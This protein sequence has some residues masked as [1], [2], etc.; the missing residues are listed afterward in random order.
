MS[1]EMPE[2]IDHH[3]A[4]RQLE[5]EMRDRDTSV[6]HDAGHLALQEASMTL[7]EKHGLNGDV[8]ISASREAK[9]PKISRRGFMVGAVMA[10]A[11]SRTFGGEVA[12]KTGEVYDRLASIETM[13]SPGDMMPLLPRPSDVPIIE[14]LPRGS[15]VI[16]TAEVER[17]NDTITLRFDNEASLHAEHTDAPVHDRRFTEAGTAIITTAEGL[18]HGEQV[19][20][21]LFKGATNTV[22]VGYDG[23]VY[24]YESS[25]GH[26]GNSGE[27]VRM[28]TSGEDEALSAPVS[29]PSGVA[30]EV[31]ETDHMLIEEVAKG[32]ATLRR[33]GHQPFGEILPNTRMPDMQSINL[34]PEDCAQNLVE[35]LS[36]I[37]PYFVSHDG[38][39]IDLR[40]LQAKAGETFDAYA[41]LLHE[42][43]VGRYR[44]EVSVRYS[45]ASGSRY[46]FRTDEA[47]VAPRTIDDTTFTVMNAASTLME[48]VSQ[49]YVSENI[50]G[51]ERLSSRSGMS[52]EDMY[53]NTLGIVGTLSH[54]KERGLTEELAQVLSRVRERSS[55]E[56][57][58]A[59]VS[60]IR[61]AVV[62]R[63][64]RQSVRS[65]G[66]HAF[67][68]PINSSVPLGIYQ[69]LPVVVDSSIKHEHAGIPAPRMTDMLRRAGIRTD[70]PDVHVMPTHVPA[71]ESTIDYVLPKASL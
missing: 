36:L 35:A 26:D 17:H 18:E 61:E 29:L 21:R 49:R 25:L 71:M 2:S 28:I 50:P 67:S 54:I 60:E 31:V 27:W 69:L 52:H 59:A 23:G 45:R 10:A 7:S 39:V 64:L 44:P 63:V 16:M 70:N 48:G 43:I 56:Q 5:E 40:H 4:V 24:V 57:I 42:Q 6:A 41:Q 9:D 65:Q 8:E 34:G 33:L 15:E 19:Y 13:L 12:H 55:G 53:T 58:E 51:S 62:Q 37:K 20:G 3:Q 46:E 30:Q 1:G 68:E 38:V 66:V 32:T 22:A 47:S 14:S 11:A